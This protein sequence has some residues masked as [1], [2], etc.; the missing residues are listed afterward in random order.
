MDSEVLWESFN[1]FGLQ[2]QVFDTSLQKTANFISTAAVNQSAK[3]HGP[4]V[5]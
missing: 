4:L 5:L 2:Q 3:V 1:W